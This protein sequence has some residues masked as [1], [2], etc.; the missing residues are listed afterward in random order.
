M[1]LAPLPQRPGQVPG[2]SRRLVCHL[3]CLGTLNGQRKLE[4]EADEA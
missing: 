2:S 3:P 4:E 1:P